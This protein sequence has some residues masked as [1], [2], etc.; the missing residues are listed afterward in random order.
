[1]QLNINTVEIPTL[2]YITPRCF[3]L[4]LARQVL[5]IAEAVSKRCS[6]KKDVLRDFVKFTGKHLYQRLFYYKRDSGTVV[7]L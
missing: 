3:I 2:S 6:V 7:F 1:M 5:G 4:V